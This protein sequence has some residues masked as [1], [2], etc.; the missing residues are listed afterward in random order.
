[1]RSTGF[2]RVIPAIDSPQTYALAFRTAT[3]IGCIY[4]L[5]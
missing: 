1:M 5:E 3:E 4:I 2:E